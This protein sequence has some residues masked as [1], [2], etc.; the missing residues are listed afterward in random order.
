MTA[1]VPGI[2]E[3][4]V[5]DRGGPFVL[6]APVVTSARRQPA[7]RAAM[8]LTVAAMLLGTLPG[9]VARTLV[10]VATA[11]VRVAGKAVDLATT[12]QDESDEKHGREMRERDRELGQLERE[13]DHAERE[14][15]DGDRH[16]CKRAQEINNKIN[17]L[18]D[19]RS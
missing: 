6:S 13:R 2:T 9:C 16:E 5:P 12:S 1:I 10:D 15:R 4:A 7:N 19:D 11:P 14:C 17:I 18:L 3:G 8:R